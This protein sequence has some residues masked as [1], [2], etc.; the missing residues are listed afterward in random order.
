M[1]DVVWQYRVFWFN[2]IPEEWYDVPEPSRTWQHFCAKL[3]PWEDVIDWLNQMG[4][5]GWEIFHVREEFS[6][7]WEDDA[8]VKGYAASTTKGG[9][10]AALGELGS[11]SPMRD[12]VF[13]LNTPSPNAGRQPTLIFFYARRPKSTSPS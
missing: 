12:F 4:T 13:S 3:L 1:T 9:L 2:R 5:E 10:M 11:D 7:N 8:S 6:F